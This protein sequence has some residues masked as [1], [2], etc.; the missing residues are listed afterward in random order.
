MRTDI[1]QQKEQIL[2]WIEE[3]RSK[4]YICQQLDCKADTLNSYLKKMGIEYAGQSGQGGGTPFY[5][6]ASYYLGTSNFIKSSSLKQKLIK[7]GL[8]EDKCEICGVSSWNGVKLPLELHHKD[9]NHYNNNLENLQ[10]LCPNCHSIQEGN[11][12]ANVGKYA[13]VQELVDYSHLECEAVNGVGVQ[14]PAV[15]PSKKKKYYCKDCGKEISNSGYTSLCYDCYAKTT[16]KV[17]WPEREV[18]KQKIR[19]QSFLSLSREYG[20]TDNAIRKWCK[21]Y[22]LPSTKAEIKSISDEDWVKI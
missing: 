10:I 20:V 16:R 21:K 3:K 18:L 1:L 9:G 19:N 22:N 8:K 17:E 11:S 15:A 6:P 4:S 2:Q 5:K 12:G 7:D 13:T 14:I